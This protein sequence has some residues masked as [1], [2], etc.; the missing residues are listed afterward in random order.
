VRQMLCAADLSISAASYVALPKRKP[1]P[2]SSP[3]KV[4]FCAVV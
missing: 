4:A 2:K 1:A 3:C